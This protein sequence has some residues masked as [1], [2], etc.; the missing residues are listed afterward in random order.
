MGKDR[1][2][3]CL[4]FD[5]VLHQY[6]TPWSSADIIADGPVEGAKEF[7]ESALEHFRIMIYSS[8]S[9]QQGGIEAMQDWC[10]K[11]FG[12]D[13]A[14]EITYPQ[15]KPPA[16]LTIDD[17]AIQFTGTWYEPATLLSFRPWN[18]AFKVGED[19]KP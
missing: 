18:K 15:A 6:E 1:P 19:A 11:H 10:R 2:I 8:R 13:I 17:R 12:Y 16:F 7:L 5:G 9:H 4:D 3:L 14:E